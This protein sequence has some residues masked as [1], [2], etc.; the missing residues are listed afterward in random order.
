M[1]HNYPRWFLLVVGVM[2]LF[3]N[4]HCSGGIYKFI[5]STD[6]KVAFSYTGAVTEQD[7]KMLDVL[8]KAWSDRKLIIHIDSPGGD[9][10][11]GVR[12]YWTAKRHGV[13]TL[14]GYRFGAYSAAGLFWLG[15]Q[16]DA[17]TVEGSIVGFHL[18]YCNP[19]K[20]P[21]CDTS[22]ID[23]E[24]QKVL[25]DALGRRGAHKLW[26]QMLDVLDSHGSQGFVIWEQKDGSL[27]E[28]MGYP[29]AMF[30]YVPLS[31][32]SET[33]TKQETGCSGRPCLWGRDPS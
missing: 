29:E 23:G 17:L 19:W 32:L 10:Y 3:V 27:I 30:L 9:A 8:A 12:L 33:S 1:K 20:P 21:G 22:D 2:L 25:I 7:A 15:G 28:R 5:A 24:F 31:S 14:A 16:E 18:A 11:E 26:S 13:S 4:R 6:E